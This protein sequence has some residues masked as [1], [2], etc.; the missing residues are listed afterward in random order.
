MK[1]RSKFLLSMA[2]LTTA[3]TA[4]S[5]FVVQRNVDTHARQ[6]IS[7]SFDSSVASLRDFQAQREEQARHSAELLIQVPQLKAMMST[8]DRVTVQDAS[9]SLWNSAR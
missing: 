9:T 2:V 3:L 6:E 8:R 5:M 4:A 1:L 7:H